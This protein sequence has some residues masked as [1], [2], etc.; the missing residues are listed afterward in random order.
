MRRLPFKPGVFSLVLS[1]FTSF[2]YFRTRQE[3]LEVL[4]EVARVLLPGG[5]FVLDFLNEARVKEELIREEQRILS[6]REVSIRRWLDNDTNCVEK[7]ISFCRDDGS[8]KH[9]RESVHL[10]TKPDL[11]HL[12][13]GVGLPPVNAFGDYAGEPYQA[14]SPRLILVGV[15]SA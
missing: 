6:G 12:L 9:Y 11:E 15:K 7:E 10:Y 3:D 14:N 5:Y 1:L 8:S 13:R 2:G 4:R